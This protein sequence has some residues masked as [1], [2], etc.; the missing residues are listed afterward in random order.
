MKDSQPWISFGIAFS[1]NTC[2]Q[3][4]TRRVP[5]FENFENGGHFEFLP[6]MAKCTKPTF[7]KIF[8]N[9]GHFAKMAKHKFFAISLN[10]QDR[11]FSSNFLP[12]EYLKI[13]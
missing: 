13:Y 12:P 4:R 2:L 9:G 11:A 1:N 3:L 8:T 5:N 7:Q 6:E 10:V